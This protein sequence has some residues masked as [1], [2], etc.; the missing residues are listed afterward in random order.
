MI[1]L[2]IFTPTYNRKQIL[3][4]CY[5]KL[6]DQTNKE[7]IWLIVDDGSTDNTN[8]E[9]E[10]W[11]KEDKIK[12]EYIKQQNGGKYK[13]VNTAVKNCKT[14]LFAFCDSDDY[15]LP[16]TVEKLLNI[17]DKIKSDNKISGIVA[18]RGTQDGVAIG[19][20]LNIANQKINF[21]TLVK[22]YKFYG[23]TCRMYRTDILK[24]VLYPELDEK[25][26]PEN[27][28]LSQIDQ[29]YDIY[30]I[31][32]PF[33]ISEYLED[34]YTKNYMKLLN[35][36]PNGYLLS[37]NYELV[38]KKG[39]LYKLKT[40]ISYTTFSWRRRIKVYKKCLNKPLYLI[41]LPFSMIAYI[42][43]V[44]KWHERKKNSIV[45]KIKN[46]IKI[47]YYFLKSYNMPKSNILDAKD[48]VDYIIKNKK[49]V[50]RF[51]DGEFNFFRHYG[52]SYQEYN[53]NIE[54]MLKEILDKYEENS[55]Y[56]LCIP[57]YFFECNGKE[58][59]KHNKQNILYWAFSRYFF[60]NKVSKNKLY[61]DAFLFGK[62]NKDIYSKIF[63]DLNIDKVIFVHNNEKYA[64]QFQNQY[65]INTE[66]INVPERNSYNNL[67]EITKNIIEKINNKDKE[68]IL[69]SA[70]PTAKIIVYK[71]AKRGIFAIDTGHCWD[72]PL[73]VLK[74]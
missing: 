72:K 6:C 9:V 63:T 60:K 33:S 10:K 14:E 65:N 57:K 40:V 19:K 24:K 44:P 11:Q 3:Q 12:I 18:R 35:K 45:E 41:G 71:L 8:N 23:D 49:S 32:E 25:F 1:N 2:T 54:K 66:Y 50:I 4:R 64:I 47:Y 28:M 39:F 74:K 46:R 22:K 27:V 42:L 16:T 5:A 34:G 59:G 70:G 53:T 13:A 73:N 62:Q 29:N 31:N 51:G 21:D 30:F 20:K 52:I 43:G 15:Y 37:L 55:N 17:W 67:D 69:I 36:N 56:L 68:L 38:T 48:T 58:L 26:I 61:G 7:F